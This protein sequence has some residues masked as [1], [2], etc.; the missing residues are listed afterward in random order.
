MPVLH[1]SV[2]LSVHQNAGNRVSGT[3]SLFPEITCKHRLENYGTVLLEGRHPQ[4]L[5][6]IDISGARGGTRR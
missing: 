1:I 6:I 4:C 3:I 2:C 5:G